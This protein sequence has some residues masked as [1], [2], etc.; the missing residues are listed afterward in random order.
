LGSACTVD[1]GELCELAGEA[2][3]IGLLLG[4]KAQVL[5]HGHLAVAQVAHDLAGA[6]AHAVVGQQH[7]HFH[8][9]GEACGRG[10]EAELG[11]DLALGA[12]EVRSQKDAPASLHDRLDGGDRRAD[13]RVVG[14]GRAVERHVEVDAHEHRA[15]HEIQIGE[16]AKGRG[17]GSAL[18]GDDAREVD[19]T[20]REAPLVVVPGLHLDEVAAHHLG[21][22]RIDDG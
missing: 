14:D 4:V 6:I 16:R 22:F 5:Q 17:H 3:I 19:H 21:L 13:A 18:L 2:F 12:A 10:L 9:L 7:F 8:Q 15:A 1:L 11:L 20:V